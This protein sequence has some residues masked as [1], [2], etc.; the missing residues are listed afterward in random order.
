MR[1]QTIEMYVDT[2]SSVN[3]I[4]M[5]I[6]NC[7]RRQ[8]EQL[9][10]PINQV[11]AYGQTT[12]LKIVGEIEIT[13]RYGKKTTKCTF[14]VTD[15]HY[16]SLLG[17]EACETLDIVKFHQ[18]VYQ[19]SSTQTTRKSIEQLT[20]EYESI[21]TGLGKLN[22]Y[23]AK[24]EL[25]EGAKIGHQIIRRIPHHVRQKVETEIERLMTMGV[26]E[27]VPDPTDPNL[28]LNPLRPVVKKDGSTRLCLAAMK[29]NTIVKK[30]KC[31]FPL[32]DD[33]INEMSDFHRASEL[34]FNEAFQQIKL[35]MDSRNLTAF[36][37]ESGT[38]RFT[39]LIYGISIAAEHVAPKSLSLKTIREATQSDETLLRVIA[40]T[41]NNRW[42]KDITQYDKIKA[43]L[44]VVGG[45]IL[46]ES[47]IVIPSRLRKQV[48]DI[49]HE[50]HQGIVKTKALIR[51]KV[52]WPGI[53]AQIE[54]RIADCIQ[55]Q[56]Q[57]QT[58]RS[59]P[60]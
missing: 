34:D 57:A 39:R 51:S 16:P 55:C 59:Q 40:A 2:G 35:D 32:V 1:G 19:L 33:M 17:D 9:K 22:D 60:L 21:F 41:A 49:A 10:S 42:T 7:M 53:D 38:Y 18:G 43:E 36:A 20:T 25:I 8:G 14:S 15:K 47:R 44:A 45:I 27:A 26:I 6:W 48:L 5:D 23:Q 12:P 50:G 28:V 4:S 54:E 58:E 52:W 11:F 29:L 13:A 30:P 37:T 24:I 56:T 31:L 46:R 3:V